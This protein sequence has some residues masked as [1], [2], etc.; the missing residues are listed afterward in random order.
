L[1]SITN[2]GE[3]V[4]DYVSKKYS[5]TGLG[6]AG[7]IGI[8]V[9]SQFAWTPTAIMNVYGT[10]IPGFDAAFEKMAKSPKAKVVAA[11]QAAMKIVVDQAASLPVCVV[12][13]TYYYKTKLTGFVV[14][15]KFDGPTPL[16]LWSK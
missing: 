2:F 9:D 11:A 8:Y 14:G 3:W 7:S 5:A 16:S 4:G 1:K 6:G 13:G 15:N 12:T 10:T